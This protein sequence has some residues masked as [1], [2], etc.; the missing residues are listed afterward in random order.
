[1]TKRARTTATATPGLTRR[2]FLSTVATGAAAMAW[3]AERTP[4]AFAQQKTFAAR[5]GTVIS[6]TTPNAI[7]DKFFT[8]EANKRSGGALQIQFF[9]DAQ[10]GASRDL[11][12]GVQLGTVQFAEVSTANITP[13][14]SDTMIFDLP[15]V[16]TSQPALLK[17]LDSPVG[18]EKLAIERFATIRMRGLCWYDTG[19]RDIYNSRKPIVTPD[20]L[21]GMKIRVEENPVRVAAL[22]A[23]GAQATPM[24]FAEVYGALQQKVVDGA[25]NSAQTYMANKHNEVAPFLSLTD[26]FITPNCVVVSTSFFGSLPKELQDLLVQVGKDT[27]VYERKVWAEVGAKLTGDMKA[28]GVKINDSDKKA[29]RA[30]VVKLQEEYAKKIPKDWWD[31]VMKAAGA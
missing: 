22:N 13:F 23:M 6:A 7:G 11:L 31:A 2:R 20:D 4:P 18:S 28:A 9:P 26:H 17:F 3:L 5:F 29:F 30:T 16:F 12:E 25:E 21:K 10:I 1:M 24:S 14:L 15:Y 19:T 27:A 8:D